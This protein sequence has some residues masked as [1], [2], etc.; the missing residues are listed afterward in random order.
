MKNMVETSN[1]YKVIEEIIYS[2]RTY[3]CECDAYIIYI[4]YVW[5][6]EIIPNNMSKWLDFF[7]RKNYSQTHVFKNEN[8]NILPK[9]E[10]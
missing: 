4:I 1:I 2:I 9:E 6:L 10:E 5:L 8:I 3:F 7:L